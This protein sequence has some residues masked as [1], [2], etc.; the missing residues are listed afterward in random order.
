VEALTF[1]M[2]RLQKEREHIDRV[3]PELND[4]NLTH[5]PDLTKTLRT[6]KV[7]THYHSGK[8]EKKPYED[9]EAWS[10]C[11]N[12]EKGSQGCVM[13]T[14]DMKRWILSGY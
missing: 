12:A 2:M 3:S 6:V 9:D 10:C 11:M 13:Y 5:S 14:K 8:W 4:P 1:K 7:K